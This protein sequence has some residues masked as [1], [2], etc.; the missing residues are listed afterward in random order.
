MTKNIRVVLRPDPRYETGESLYPT[1][2]IVVSS[3]HP[4]FR[5]GTRFDWGLANVALREGY[6]ITVK[7]L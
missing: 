6:S 3:E 2:M 4:T 1:K 7:P 5:N